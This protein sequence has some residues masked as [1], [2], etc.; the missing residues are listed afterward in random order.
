MISMSAGRPRRRGDSDAPED[1]SSVFGAAA[2]SSL[3][4]I[5][6]RQKTVE[7]EASYADQSSSELPES[8]DGEYP[9]A[10]ER[11]SRRRFRP[12]Q[13]RDRRYVHALLL[14]AVKGCPKGRKLIDCVRETSD[15]LIVLSPGVVYR[16][17][18]MLERERLI[19]VSREERERRYTIT[20]IGERVLAMR[21]QQWEDFSYGFVLILQTADNG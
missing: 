12:M 18:H 16:E 20:E 8:F 13:V 15:G 4:N 5:S 11:V 17:L 1:L 3:R 19:D 21:R 2:A 10:Q 14:A 6:R 9:E 7:V